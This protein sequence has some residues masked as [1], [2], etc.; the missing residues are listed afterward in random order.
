MR[1]IVYSDL[2]ESSSFARSAPTELFATNTCYANTSSSLHVLWQFISKFTFIN[3][4]MRSL[5]SAV[6]SEHSSTP[7]I[8]RRLLD[9][10]NTKS[11]ARCV[12]TIKSILN[13]VREISLSESTNQQSLDEKFLRFSSLLSAQ[14]LQLC[15]NLR[16][17]LFARIREHIS[18][19]LSANLAKKK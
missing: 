4:K 14:L 9:T 16:H 8:F 2:G 7:Q 6:G 5:P 18:T 15:L 11:C 3:I 1:C 12:G 10:H 19:K 13:T 17:S